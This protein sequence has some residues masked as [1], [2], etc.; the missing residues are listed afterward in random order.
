MTTRL[1]SV[2]VSAA[3]RIMRERDAYDQLVAGLMSDDDKIQQGKWNQ[4]RRISV[5]IQRWVPKDKLR[6][7]RRKNLLNDLSKTLDRSSD[8]LRWR[9]RVFEAFPT[10]EDRAH[11]KTWE[12]HKICAAQDNPAGW[13]DLMQDFDMNEGLLRLATRKY[14]TL[15]EIRDKLESARQNEQ[16]LFAVL[17]TMPQKENLKTTKSKA[18]PRRIEIDGAMH[19]VLVMD[20]VPDGFLSSDDHVTVTIKKA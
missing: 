19:W 13:R 15:D 4:G 11:E 14:A 12:M 10:L 18:R 20:A 9:V 7:V 6:S 17:Q 16:S 1:K 2:I 8:T 5:Y 3:E